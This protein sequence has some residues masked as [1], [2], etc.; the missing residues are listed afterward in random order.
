M[1]N[2]IWCEMVE[3]DQIPEWQYNGEGCPDVPD[4]GGVSMKAQD[5]TRWMDHVFQAVL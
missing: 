1:G 2:D 5:F 4:I 3:D